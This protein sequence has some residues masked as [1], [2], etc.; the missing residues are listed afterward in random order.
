[1]ILASLLVL[2]NP[3]AL[4]IGCSGL[5][6]V[7]VQ[8]AELGSRAYGEK[9]YKDASFRLEKALA[10]FNRA[11]DCSKSTSHA[12]KRL[13]EERREAVYALGLSYKRV[14]KWERCVDTMQLIVQEDVRSSDW[15]QR[16]E[17]AL[18]DCSRESSGTL[19]VVYPSDQVRQ[20]VRLDGVP[21]GLAPNH[22]NIP[23]GKHELSI[24]PSN[25]FEKR[26][27]EIGP[28]EHTFIKLEPPTTNS[29]DG[30]NYLGWSLGIG[31]AV[32]VVG[33]AFLLAQDSRPQTAPRQ[34]H[35]TFG[36]ARRLDVTLVGE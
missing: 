27:I 8:D 20:E 7:A 11:V 13:L 28:E 21:L 18:K 35:F 29:D 15:H 2:A 5:A 14:G 30:P 32:V 10:N 9:Q 6:K 36:N 3:G 19:I 17:Q 26:E 4:A 25:G 34:G 33:G 31:A 24:H 12:H 16:A 22:W 1:M 23:R